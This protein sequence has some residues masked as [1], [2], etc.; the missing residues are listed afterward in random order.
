MYSINGTTISV[1]KGD[2]L[3]AAIGITKDGETYVLQEGDSVRFALKT[4]YTD[5][6]CLILKQ[7]DPESLILRLEAAETKALEVG[8]YVFDIELT[9]ANGDVDTFISGTFKV[10]PEVY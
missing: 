9:F 7:I 6:T 1:T 3:I 8:S 4:S 2:T 10:I 5:S